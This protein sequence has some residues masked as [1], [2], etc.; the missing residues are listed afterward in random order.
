MMPVPDLR[1]RRDRKRQQALAHL[2]GT[3]IRLFEADGYGAVTMERIAAEADVAKRT[4][5]N[6]FATKD[7]VLAHWIHVQLESD[8]KILSAAIE[9]QTTFVT[10]ITGILNASAEW[11]ERHPTYLAPYLRFRFMNIEAAPSGD[12]ADIADLFQVLI[13]AGQKSGELRGDLPASQ[14][15][16]L[17][18]Y[19]HLGALMRWLT[20][21][22]LAL[23]EEFAVV[24]N[25]F[26]EGAAGRDSP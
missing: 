15:A 23:R 11:W 12:K 16:P 13:D 8:L 3:A 24:V 7:A 10:R 9:R 21:P 22:G 25:L 17:F 5:Y 2:T 14:L 1:N 4:L 20:V 18:H 6:H 19:L 26:V